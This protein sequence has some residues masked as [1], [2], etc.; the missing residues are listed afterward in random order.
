MLFSDRMIVAKLEI[1]PYFCKPRRHRL[2][3]TLY[4]TVFIFI[5]IYAFTYILPSTVYTL[6][7]HNLR[8]LAL[9]GTL[10]LVAI[11][12]DEVTTISLGI[13]IKNSITYALIKS[14]RFLHF[15]FFF[16][17]QVHTK[18]NNNNRIINATVDNRVGVH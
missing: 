7:L 5:Y 12:A 13:Y 18:E 9:M 6:N 14:K 17:W 11:N 16:N 8:Y 15:I 10:K 1:S 4:Y 2:S 3:C